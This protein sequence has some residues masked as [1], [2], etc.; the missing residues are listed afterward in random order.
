[1]FGPLILFL[2]ILLVIA[3]GNEVALGRH[4]VAV[5]TTFLI[6]ALV[7][8]A[9]SNTN[10]SLVFLLVFWVLEFAWIISLAY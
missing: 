8:L 1:M 4:V 6:L 10:V 7:A 5:A 9:F 3:L 2:I